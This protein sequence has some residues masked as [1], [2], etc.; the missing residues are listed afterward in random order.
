MLSGAKYFS[1]FDA[2]SGYWQRL[3]GEKSSLLTTFNT[4]FV[5][6]HFA[7]MPFGIHSAQEMFQKTMDMAFE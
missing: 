4:P 3:L 2:T 1:I 7:R 5:R 6:Y